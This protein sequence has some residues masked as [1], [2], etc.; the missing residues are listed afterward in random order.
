MLFFFYRKFKNKSPKNHQEL[1]NK[2]AL[3]PLEKFDNS[4]KDLSDSY[5]ETENDEKKPVEKNETIKDPFK[6]EVCIQRVITPDCI[7][8]AQMEHEVSNTKM[9]LTM[10]KFYDIYHSELRDNWSEGALCAVYSAKDKSYFRAKILKI[11]SSTEVLVYF[12]DM[13]IEE[14]VTMKDIQILHMKFAK[15]PTYC[16][17]VKLAGILP[18]GGSS[19][20]PSLSCNV[21]SDIIQENA[22]CKYYIT[23]PVSLKKFF[24]R[25]HLCTLSHISN[26]L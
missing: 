25:E 15:Q 5:D 23:K 6:V 1:S 20:W 26:E 16:F 17:K 4:T 9:V 10:Q 19:T 8:V 7:Y 3:L 24:L 12:Y 18:C 13:G 21:L 11:K 22:F 2:S 14:M